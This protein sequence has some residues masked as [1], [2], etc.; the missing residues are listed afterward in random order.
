YIGFDSNNGRGLQIGSGNNPTKSFS[1]STSGISG[2]IKSIKIN[3]SMASGGSAKL[4]VSVGGTSVKSNQAL[5]T[6]ATDYTIS[7]INKSGEI[8][9]SYTNTAKAF[10]IKSI[11]VE[12]EN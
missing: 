6:S 11:V 10:Y 12:Y 7:D 1:L 3:S 9:I 2:N 5:T 8:V 4:S